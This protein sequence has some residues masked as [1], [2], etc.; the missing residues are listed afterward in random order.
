MRRTAIAL[1]LLIVLLASLYGLAQAQTGASEH[2]RTA[3]FVI[4]EI[5]DISIE[6]TTPTGLSFPNP[7]LGNYTAEASQSATTPAVRLTVNSATNVPC[8]IVISA[9][10]FLA[11]GASTPPAGVALKYGLTSSYAEASVLTT[12][13]TTTHTGLSSGNTVDFWH[14]LVLPSTI[15]PGN[16]TGTVT[17]KAVKG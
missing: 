9:T 11:D 8:S 6:D 10:Q 15:A 5:L 7:P 17:Y 2:S 4:G 3:T 13:G 12:G 14:W 1:G 16:Y